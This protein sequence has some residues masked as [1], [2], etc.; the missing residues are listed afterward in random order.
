MDDSQRINKYASI[1]EVILNPIRNDMDKF[2]KTK[3]QREHKYVLGF[4]IK[5]MEACPKYGPNMRRLEN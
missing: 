5:T 3:K 4:R 1:S 2:K